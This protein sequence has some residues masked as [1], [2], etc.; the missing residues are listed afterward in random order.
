MKSLIRT[1]TAMMVFNTAIAGF[2]PAQKADEEANKKSLQAAQKKLDAAKKQS[3]A[4]IADAI[5]ADTS[6]AK[7][8]DLM[9]SDLPLLSHLYS[10]QH[11]GDRAILIIPTAEMKPEKFA[12]MT[13]DLNIMALI[14]DK[15]LN[16]GLGLSEG[17][18][19][20]FGGLYEL[21]PY[22]TF[23]SSD[24]LATKAVYVQGY[25]ALFLT[26]A[27]FPLAPPPQIKVGNTKEPADPFWE[28][29]KLEIQ[30]K[31]QVKNQDRYAPTNFE[32][33]KSLPSEQFYDADKVENLQ[34]DLTKALKHGANIRN[35][36]PEE[37]VVLVVRGAPTFVAL[38]ILRRDTK[39]DKITTVTPIVRKTD[40]PAVT[41]LTIRARKSD[42][43]AFSID[44][45][46]FDEFRKRIQ[47]STYQQISEKT[48]CDQLILEKSRY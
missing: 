26:K 22:K 45:L 39:E 21:C 43:D 47:T 27:D 5:L 20:I 8:A 14:V 4:S 33:I 3:E 15:K 16:R 30:Q 34:R 6:L 10:R 7:Q 29:T 23:L 9:L 48:G 12:Q 44:D 32:S 40:S 11:T 24:E 37:W 31:A 2:D 13:E 46:D 17:G 36:R 28:Q 35:L 1:V 25:G 18:T 41:V 38:S 42:V 19:I